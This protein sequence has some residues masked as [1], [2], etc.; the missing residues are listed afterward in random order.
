MCC[1]CINNA[2]EIISL[3]SFIT[4]VEKLNSF[5]NSFLTLIIASLNVICLFLYQAVYSMF[6]FPLLAS[7]S[8]IK[9]TKE[10]TPN[11]TGVVLSMAKSL[12]C[13]W[14]STPK[15]LLTSSKVTS[16]AHLFKKHWNTGLFLQHSSIHKIALGFNFPLRIA[17]NY[18]T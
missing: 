18:P 9:A 11:S 16:T 10:N 12:H 13:L 4:D 15:C 8:A 17:Q 1:I 5:Q 2:F 6:N 3:S 14:V 7:W